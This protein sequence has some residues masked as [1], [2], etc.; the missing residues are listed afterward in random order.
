MARVYSRSQALGAVTA[1]GPLAGR[2]AIPL[3][4]S[5]VTYIGELS[6]MSIM[7]SFCKFVCAAISS[8]SILMWQWCGLQ[9]RS[10]IKWKLCWVN[11]GCVITRLHFWPTPYCLCLSVF[12]PSL[13]LCLSS[14]S[15]CLSVCPCVTV[16]VIC[17]P[18]LPQ[19]PTT[20]LLP[21]FYCQVFF[22]HCNHSG[23]SRRCC[24]SLCHLE[25]GRTQQTVDHSATNG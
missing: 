9:L 15:V 12:L 25:V 5:V 18:L 3:L 24:K 13:S 20:S 11:C 8:L 14:I 23:T 10:A 1:D 6:K 2:L 7:K 4:Y 22:A 17:V 21:V 19:F 16:C